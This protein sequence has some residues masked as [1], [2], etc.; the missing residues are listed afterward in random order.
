MKLLTLSDIND[1][2]DD[3]QSVQIIAYNIKLYDGT[4]GNIPMM[5]AKYELVPQKIRT[6][7]NKIIIELDC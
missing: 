7:D 1:Y 5:Y 2:F 4:C 3:N 6:I